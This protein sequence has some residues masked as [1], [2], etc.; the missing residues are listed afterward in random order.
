MSDHIQVRAT[1]PHIRYISDGKQ[2]GFIF[3]FCLFHAEDLAVYVDGVRQSGGYDVLGAGESDG[4][5]VIFA[6]PPAAG[7]HVMLRRQ[8]IVERTAD[9]QDSGIF[10]ARVINDELDYLTAA[11]QQVEAETARS[12]RLHPADTDAALVLPSAAERAGRVIAFDPAGDVTTVPATPG[13][14]APA[15]LDDV[16]EGLSNKHFTLDEKAKLATIATAADVNPPKITAEERV[17][18]VEAAPRTF[19]P[20]DVR[21]MVVLHAPVAAVTSVHGRIGQIVAQSGDY[22]ADQIVDTA[23]KVMMT[24]VERQTLG[25]LADFAATHA[26]DNAHGSDAIRNDSAPNDTLPAHRRQ[27]DAGEDRQMPLRAG[28]RRWQHRQ[29]WQYRLQ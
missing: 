11:V 1:P 13:G 5:R 28:V 25:D 2:Q 22:G 9:F 27:A 18:A 29:L 21:S 19:S 6:D 10:R 7:A 4:G 17:A 24:A 8:A 12:L 15:T 20:D 16:D 23:E 14:S 3:P 26:G